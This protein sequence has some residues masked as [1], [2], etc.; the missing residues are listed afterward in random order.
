MVGKEIGEGEAAGD[1]DVDGEQQ[2]DRPDEQ[3]APSDTHQGCHDANA[4]ASR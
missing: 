4:D 3:L 1:L 2:N